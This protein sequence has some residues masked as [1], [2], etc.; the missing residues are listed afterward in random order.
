[1]GKGSDQVEFAQRLGKRSEPKRS[2]PKTPGQVAYEAMCARNGDRRP[3]SHV[4]LYDADAADWEAVAAA[5][6]AHHVTPNGAREARPTAQ[7]EP[8]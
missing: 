7:Q 8:P 4:K 1:M 3:W 2:E 6:L 5:V